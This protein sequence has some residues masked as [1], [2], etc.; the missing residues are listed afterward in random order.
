MKL[1]I[2]QVLCFIY[3]FILYSKKNI[4]LIPGVEREMSTVKILKSDFSHMI[5]Y[6]MLNT[7]NYINLAHI[8]LYLKLILCNDYM[9]LILYNQLIFL[10]QIS[11]SKLSNL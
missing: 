11:A 10:S 4:D 3:D 9:F 7:C 6:I 8:L 1:G 2:R 5:L